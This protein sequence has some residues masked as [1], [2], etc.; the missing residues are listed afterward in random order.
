[1]RFDNNKYS[2]AA[3]QHAGLIGRARRRASDA[4]CALCSL[5]SRQGQCLAL[6][7]R[8]CASALLRPTAWLGW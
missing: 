5:I 7:W 1:V 4:N 6:R 2:V 8:V 3:M